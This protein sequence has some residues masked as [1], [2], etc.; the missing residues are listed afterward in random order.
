MAFEDLL[1]TDQTKTSQKSQSDLLNFASSLALAHHDQLLKR[2][3]I[4]QSIMIAQGEYDYLALELKAGKKELL[5]DL[6]DKKSF[7]LERQIILVNVSG[8]ADP[9]DLSAVNRQSDQLIKYRMELEAIKQ[10]RGHDSQYVEALLKE[11]GLGIDLEGIL[12]DSLENYLT[13]ISEKLKFGGIVD[14]GRVSRLC[15]FASMAA[16]KGNLV[17]ALKSYS[18]AGMIASVQDDFKK[19]LKKAKKNKNPQSKEAEE[20][21][22]NLAPKK[23]KK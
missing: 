9:G 4:L 22:H 17:L 3:E 7:L 1:K 10:S 15:G 23:Q 21:L 20:L 11:L 13:A 16:K 12:I 6:L 14:Q 8:K 2:E 5:N 19:I 18:I